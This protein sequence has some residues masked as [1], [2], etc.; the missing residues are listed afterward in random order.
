MWFIGKWRMTPVPHPMMVP[1][2]APLPSSGGIVDAPF[3][4]PEEILPT[5]TK[6]PKAEMKININ[7]VCQGALAYMTFENTV[8]AE[9]FVEDCKDGKHPEV[10]EQFKANLNFGEDVAI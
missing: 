1:A 9:A 3:E 10:I 6:S 7:E 4:V 5:T 8:F 2:R